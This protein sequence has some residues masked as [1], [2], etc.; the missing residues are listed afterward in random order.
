MLGRDAVVGD[1]TPRVP[2]VCLA[3]SGREGL[4]P[5]IYVTAAKPNIA[6]QLMVMDHDI[7]GRR[8]AL[9]RVGCMGPA[10]CA[11]CALLVRD[12]MQSDARRAAAPASGRHATYLRTGRRTRTH[13]ECAA[14]QTEITEGR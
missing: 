13:G 2:H 11:D 10:R 9:A 8:D 4:A 3:I 7:T 6:R 12:S 14:S 1:G 5:R